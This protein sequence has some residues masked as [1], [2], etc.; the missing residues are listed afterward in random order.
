MPFVGVNVPDIEQ[1]QNAEDEVPPLVR[2]RDECAD[3]AANNEDPAHEKGRE[4]VGERES[5]C[6]QKLEEEQG[7]CDEPLDVAYIL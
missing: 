7:N 3:E 2:G 1:C 5:R 4:Y 6:K